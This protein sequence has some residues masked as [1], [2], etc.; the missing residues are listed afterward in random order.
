MLLIDGKK[1]AAELRLKVRNDVDA[2]TRE[3]GRPPHL[4]VI[5]VGDDPASQ[6]YVRYKEKACEEV[7]IASRIWRLDAG[8][9]QC[10]LERHI[11]ELCESDDI[12][13]ILLQLP[14]PRGL[15]A[16]RCLAIIDPKKDVDGFHPE[17]VGRLSIGLPG[18]KPCTPFGVMKLLEY[19][20][21]SPAGKQA[22]VVGRSNIVGKPMAMLLSAQTP[23]GNATVTM[24]HSRTPDLAAVCR[25]AD[26][27]V[28]A[29]GK[30]KRITRDMVKPGAV[31]VDVGM[32]RLPDGK[33]CGDVDYENV[34][35]LVSAITPVPG[36]VG[37]MTIATLMANTVE[38][39]RWR[40]E[41]PL[42]PV[43]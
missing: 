30:P 25:Q 24:C 12:D 18:L 20:G 29:I 37:P 5:L 33:L 23:F 39:F 1:V 27:L 6:V 4:A 32:N 16:N 21:L 38:A 10:A 43:D 15:D 14:L 7:G 40:R 13:G 2:I 3:C 28:P 19:Y 17:N 34:L 11:T 41:K 8:T 9:T 22:V 36:G 31:I 42:C 26:L 35:D